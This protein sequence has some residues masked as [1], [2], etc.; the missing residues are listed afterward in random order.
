MRS[1]P[2]R[3]GGMFAARCL[4]GAIAGIPGAQWQRE[5][6]ERAGPI[7][8]PNLCIKALQDVDR[9]QLYSTCALAPGT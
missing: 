1:G 4:S 5:H 3:R 8:S 9:P 2:G 6:R 7:P